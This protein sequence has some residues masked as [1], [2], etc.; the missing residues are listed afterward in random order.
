MPREHWR[1]LNSMIR[2]RPPAAIPIGAFGGRVRIEGVVLPRG[3]GNNP[4]ALEMRFRVCYRSGGCWS[5]SPGRPLFH[6]GIGPY[7]PGSAAVPGVRDRQPGLQSVAN[8][9]AFISP[10]IC[11]T[12]VRTTRDCQAEARL[13][14]VGLG[15]KGGKHLPPETLHKAEKSADEE[16]RSPASPYS[17]SFS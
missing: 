11:R 15:S 17:A 14:G 1:R 8:D 6:V 7:T 13:H 10:F 4:H 3:N 2:L 16:E 5:A 9:D 12:R